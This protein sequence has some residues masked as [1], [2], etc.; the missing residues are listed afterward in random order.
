MNQPQP[1]KI[2]NTVDLLELVPALLGFVPTESVVAVAVAGGRAFCTAR[3]DLPTD[4]AD[5]IEATQTLDRLLTQCARV[6]LVVYSL[7]EHTA[8]TV[9]RVLIAGITP[10]RILAAVL[11]G[12]LGWTH[13]EPT[14]PDAVMWT[15]PYT[16]GPSPAAA[17][18]AKAG[19]IPP[20]PGPGRIFAT[21]SPPPTRRACL[22]GKRPMSPS[23]S[24]R[25]PPPTRRRWPPRPCK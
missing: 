13:L 10:D 14:Q 23:R 17:A 7:D 21:A 24:P 2:S 1:I 16:Q 3:L 5:L 15:N 9:L 20:A 12:P 25:S 11:A 19:L 4:S 8:R 22:P 6:A 18:A